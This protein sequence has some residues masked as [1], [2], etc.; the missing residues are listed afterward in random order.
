MRNRVNAVRAA[1]MRLPLAPALPLEARRRQTTQP[2]APGL[3]R[4]ASVVGVRSWNTAVTATPPHL[5][6]LALTSARILATIGPLYWESLYAAVLRRRTRV[7]ANSSVESSMELRRALVKLGYVTPGL[8]EKCYLVADVAVP[9]EQNLLL[10]SHIQGQLSGR[11]KL[12][13][14]W[15]A[16]VTD[17]LPASGSYAGTR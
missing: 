3:Q 13:Q 16:R 15:P 9:V 17:R 1:G 6:A 5:R 14:I 2:D 12:L 4:I 7:E 8:H 11:G 10:D